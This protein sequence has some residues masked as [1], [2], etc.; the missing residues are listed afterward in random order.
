MYFNKK[1]NFGDVLL[2][3]L[4]MT[5]QIQLNETAFDLFLKHGFKKVSVDEICRKSGVSRKTF[6]TYYANK[7]ALVI[8]MLDTMTSTMFARY[9]SLI[10]DPTKNFSEKMKEMLAMKFE[11]N[12]EFS[13]EFVADFFHPDSAEILSYFN[14]LTKKSL[15]ITRAFFESSQAKGEMNPDLDID[16]VMWYMQ[17]QIEICSQPELLAMFPNAESMTKQMSEL[18]IYGIMLPDKI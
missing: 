14:G 11:M 9:E 2:L 1:C 18:I 4:D 16:F 13:M 7:A 12:K 15:E 17:K 6:Y 8:A 3:F 10:D 5:K